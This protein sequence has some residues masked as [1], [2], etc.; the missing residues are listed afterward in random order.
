VV[1]RVRALGLIEASI[2]SGAEKSDGIEGILHEEKELV[3]ELKGTEFCARLEDIRMNGLAFQ[4]AGEGADGF[5]KGAIVVLDADHG[6]RL[7]AGGGGI[8]LSFFGENYRR[9]LLRSWRFLCGNRRCRNSC[10]RGKE[11]QNG[12][13]TKNNLRPHLKN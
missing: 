12:Q 7:D 10:Y 8:F 4:R 3:F 2:K 13:G 6:R 11:R 1:V 9:R 5:L